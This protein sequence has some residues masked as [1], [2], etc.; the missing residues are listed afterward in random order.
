M[1]EVGGLATAVVVANAATHT[2]DVELTG[3]GYLHEGQVMVT[4][5]GSVASVKA[6]VD[7]MAVAAG[8]S[9]RA[10]SVIARP[11][12]QIET[13]VAERQVGVGRRV[14]A[15]RVPGRGPRFRAGRAA[16]G[17]DAQ[18]VTAADEAPAA[19]KQRRASKRAAGNDD[20]TQG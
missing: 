1:V 11:D 12:P 20:Q 3:F 8:P 17:P 7:A 18:T 15:P 14:G 10:R 19:P 2:A 5:T 4:I 9:L 16:P 6:A 13:V